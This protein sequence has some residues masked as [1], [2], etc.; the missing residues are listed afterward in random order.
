MYAETYYVST[1]GDTLN[2]GSFSSPFLYIQQAADIMQAG[3]TCYIRQG[4][5][6][7]KITLDNQDGT[8]V[9]PIVFTSYNNE[10]VVL[11]GTVQINSDWS[12]FS[13]N[14]WV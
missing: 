3:D 1:I 7:E 6:H 12:P 8:A 2:A 5:Y 13:S 14:I 9:N 4:V 11:D 10:R